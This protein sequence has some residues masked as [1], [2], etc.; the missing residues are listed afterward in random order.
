MKALMKCSGT[1]EDVSDEAGEEGGDGE[2]G[3]DSLDVVL[4]L[5][6][7]ATSSAGSGSDLTLKD[8]ILGHVRPA[9]FHNG[10]GLTNTGGKNL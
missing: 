4:K 2:Q 1:V 8:G 7:K 10:A 6:S 5:R 3:R 9:C